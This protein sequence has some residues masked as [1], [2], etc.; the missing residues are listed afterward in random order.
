MIKTMMPP[1]RAEGQR[2]VLNLICEPI[3]TVRIGFIGL[4][5]RA[6]RA[7]NRFLHIE[8]VEIIALCDIQLSNVKNAQSILNKN[9]KKTACEYSS[10]DGW[11]EL[12]ERSDIDLVYISTDWLSHTPMA[13]YAMEQGKHVALEVPAATTISECWQLVDVAERTRRHCMMLENCCY[14]AFELNTLNIAR[15]GLFGEILHVEGAY[16]HD[17]RERVLSNESGRRHPSNWQTMYNVQHTGNPY[18]THG[19]GPVCQLLDIHRSDKMNYLVSMSTKQY[20]MAEY[21]LEKFGANSVQASLDYKLG[22]MN[23]T[24]IKTEK[25]KTILVQHNISNPRPY[26][27]IHLINGSKGYAQKYPIERILIK[28]LSDEVL[29]EKQMEE[30]FD[31][32][33]HPF[34]KQFG[35][36]AS[37]VCGERARDYIMD[38]RLIYCLQNGLPLDQDVYDAVEWS[39]LM[40]LTEISV[41][42]NSEPVEVPDFTRGDWDLL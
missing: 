16:I 1:L 42:N 12:C 13:T 8:G 17:L 26:T 19:L 37:E 30:L 29:T 23:S 5:V 3:P 18:P 11:K 35:K 40:E 21:A 2:N 34:I 20:G 38:S 4:G 27:R 28:E 31:E 24:L 39:C 33:E 6:T 32:Y 14:D 15:N 22:D 41:T 10:T 36:K 7:V 9:N 25:G